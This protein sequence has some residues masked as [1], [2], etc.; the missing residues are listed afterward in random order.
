MIKIIDKNNNRVKII[1]ETE[2]QQKQKRTK[3]SGNL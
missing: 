3:G 1:D 2:R